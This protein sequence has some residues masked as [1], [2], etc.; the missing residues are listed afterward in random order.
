VGE[1]KLGEGPI[2][3]RGPNINPKL[4]ELLVR[5]AEDR[6]IPYQLEGAPRGTGTDA[7]A[8]QLTRA[9]VA[10]GL[11]SVPNRYMHSPCEL[12]HLEDL[13]NAAELLAYAVERIDSSDDFV[14][15]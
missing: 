5:T 7:N 1:F 11:I 10:T 4:F 14:P 15:F 3:A 2:I 8:I 12:V 9:G 6:K 13:E